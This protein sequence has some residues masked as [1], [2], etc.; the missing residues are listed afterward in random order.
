VIPGKTTTTSINLWQSITQGIGGFTILGTGPGKSVS[1]AGDV[2]GDGLDDVIVGTIPSGSPVGRTDVVFGKADTDD[3]NHS[4]VARGDRELRDERDR[5]Q[6][7]RVASLPPASAT[8]TA[9][10][11]GS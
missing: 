4:D 1:G 7:R 11:S 6:R 2:D 5:Q 8:V 9:P 10:P 3:V